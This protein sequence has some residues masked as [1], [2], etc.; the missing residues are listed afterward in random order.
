VKFFQT[1][2]PPVKAEDTL[3]M[4]AFMEAADESKRRNG[5]PVKLEGVWKKANAEAQRALK[6]LL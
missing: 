4:L 1:G 2:I 3:E 6:K 5:I